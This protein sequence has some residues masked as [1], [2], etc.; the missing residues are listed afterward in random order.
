MA[1]RPFREDIIHL[2]EM[3]GATPTATVLISHKLLKGEI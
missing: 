3:W 1:L 2:K